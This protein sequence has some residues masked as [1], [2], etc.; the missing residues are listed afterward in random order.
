[1]VPRRRLLSGV[2]RV[3]DCFVEG[4]PMVFRGGKRRGRRE[5]TEHQWS[6]WECGEGSDRLSFAS[7]INTGM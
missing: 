7:E 1:M 5:L 3:L 2:L 6:V 4:V